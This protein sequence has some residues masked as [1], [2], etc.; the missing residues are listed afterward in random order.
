[1]L[2]TIGAE[3]LIK[4]ESS[5]VWISLRRRNRIDFVGGQRQLGI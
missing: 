1:M 4:K 2:E 3:R 5:R